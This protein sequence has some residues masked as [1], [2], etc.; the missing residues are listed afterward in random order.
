MGWLAAK[1]ERFDH[2]CETEPNGDNEFYF[3]SWGTKTGD[4]PVAYRQPPIAKTPA[5]SDQTDAP[6]LPGAATEPVPRPGAST[7]PLTTRFTSAWRRR[8]NL[9]GVRML[10]Q[11]IPDMAKPAAGRADEQPATGQACSTGTA[12]DIEYANWLRS[13]FER[14]RKRSYNR[15]FASATLADYDF[16]F[17][18]WASQGRFFS[19]DTLNLLKTELFTLPWDSHLTLLDV[20]SG[21]GA[22]IDLLSSFS[23]E[24]FAGYRIDCEALERDPR[25]AELYRIMYRN[26]PVR[27][28]SLSEIPDASYDI[29][30]ASHVIEHIAREE[31]AAFIRKL[32][33]VA[34]KFTIITCPWNEP[35]PRHPDHA[36]S[37]DYDLIKE[38]EP[39]SFTLFR[40]LGWNNG[41]ADAALLQCVGMVFRHKII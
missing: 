7:Q 14:L 31:V 13:E 24:P 38:V 25:W 29:V 6:L 10:R 33:S 39:S 15:I 19:I 12:A 36:F 4:A 41:V 16:V 20:G 9:P 35:A 8:A 3:L 37:V 5:R 17:G 23:S 34:R 26:V 27:T 40:S 32:V 1:S 11:L 2:F 21:C 22:G 18:P 30:T 28:E